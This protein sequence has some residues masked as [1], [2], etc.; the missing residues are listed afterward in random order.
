MCLQLKSKLAV[1]AKGGEQSPPFSRSRSPA[2][3]GAIGQGSPL[4]RR[5][6]R[7]ARVV[8]ETSKT[9]QRPFVGDFTGKAMAMTRPKGISKRKIGLTDG[10]DY[11]SG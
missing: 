4:V 2:R 8:A 11:G 7:G 1:T 10:K 5:T 6:G 3:W 9:R